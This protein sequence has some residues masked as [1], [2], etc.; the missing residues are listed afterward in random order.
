MRIVLP[1][2]SRQWKFDR[3]FTVE[4]NDFDVE[5]LL[6]TLFYLIITRGRE[7]GARRNDPKDFDG[8]LDRLLSHDR[9]KGFDGE[10]SRRTME[11]WIRSAIVRMGRTGRGK[12]GEQIEFPL[13]W[14]LLTYKS[15]LPTEISRQRKV[16]VFLY[17][18]LTAALA[19]AHGGSGEPQLEQLVKRAFGR[20]AAIGAPPK[21]DGKYDG[22]TELD[23]HTLLSMLYLDGFELSGVG[24]K[25]TADSSDPAL[26]HFAQS[27]AK[28][29]L[30]FILAY[31]DRTPVLGLTRGLVT[32]INCELFVYTLKLFY[33]INSLVSTHELPPAMRVDSP[34]SPPEVY[35]DFTRERGSVSD[36]LARACVDRDLEELRLFFESS[37]RL[38]TI[39][40]FLEF[41]PELQSKLSGLSTPEYLLELNKLRNHSGILARAQAEL[42]GIRHE[43][44]EACQNDT[45]RAA[46]EEYFTKEIQGD[47][48]LAVSLKL[49]SEAGKKNNVRNTTQWFWS[50]GGL[51][52][53]YGLLSGNITGRR[54]WRYAPSDDLLA[55]LVRLA[56]VEDPGGNLKHITTRS[57]LPLADFLEFLE[58]RFGFIVARPPSFLDDVTSRAAATRN[59]EA[60]KRRLRQ[61]GFFRD[62]SDDFNAQYLHMEKVEE[63]TA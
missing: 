6:P 33:S 20:G 63:A 2:P 32:L 41:I 60:L 21:Y 10:E 23:V 15:G 61:M 46:T 25:A 17:Q 28:D 36:E 49:L 14:T 38:R 53:N 31:E 7:R 45:E 18:L 30:R 39:H 26:P 50:V 57:T 12:K 52:K 37:L 40:R 59:L 51:R 1:K 62:L 29:L 4:L 9:L 19:E 22:A 5:R 58:R 16:H 54:N 11:R 44:L 3:L 43:S 35:I 55:T 8:F 48:A 13:P 42:E 24:K 27:M 47:D 56:M 34:T